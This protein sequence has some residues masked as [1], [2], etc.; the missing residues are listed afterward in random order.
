MHQPPG[1]GHHRAAGLAD[2]LMAQADAEDGEPSGEAAHRG[3]ADSGPRRA[4][5][6]G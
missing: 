4:A 2:G 5:R 3:D 1:V 6:A